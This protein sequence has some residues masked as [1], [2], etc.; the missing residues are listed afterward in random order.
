V[1]YT[2]PVTAQLSNQGAAT[3]GE[4]HRVETGERQAAGRG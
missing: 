4:E 1:D 3:S 2:V